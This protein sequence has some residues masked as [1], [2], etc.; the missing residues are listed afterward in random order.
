VIV[1]AVEPQQ[2]KDRYNIFVDG[3]FWCG[4]SGNSLTKYSLYPE[5]KVN[6]KILDEI[7]KFEIFNKVYESSIG[8][9]SRRPH[10][11][12][13]IERY[14]EDKFWKNKVKWFKG[15]KYYMKFE[16]LSEGTKK[17]VI[18]KLKSSKYIDDTEFAKWWIKSR[19]SSSPKGWIA[20]KSELRSK[21]ISREILDNLKF[22]NKDEI[23][24]A[25]RYYN[26]ITKVRKLNKKKIVSR[27]KTRGFSWDT[28]QIIL[29]KYE[30]EA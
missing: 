16:E 3:K 20:I 21:G 22:S 8:K 25:N 26:K 30:V 1:T 15:T 19:K 28:I 5:K 29:K 2:R 27:M 4:L 10:S 13:E 11:S 9:I 12:W 17:K 6:N 23:T 7:F 24:L 18:E 14:V